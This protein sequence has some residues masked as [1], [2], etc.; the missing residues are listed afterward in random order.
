[1]QCSVGGIRVP[2][3]SYCMV[4]A[5]ARQVAVADSN[6]AASNDRRL[7]E[8]NTCICSYAVGVLAYAEGRHAGLV[9]PR[10]SSSVRLAL[11]KLARGLQRV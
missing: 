6:Q 11:P 8:L 1:M 7:Y 2:T 3:P 5:T 9:S 10:P 4:A